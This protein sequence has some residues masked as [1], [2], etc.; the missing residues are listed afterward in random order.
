MKKNLILINLILVTFFLSCS[1]EETIENENYSDDIETSNNTESLEVSN[2]S[3][4]AYVEENS[5]EFR[6][7]FENGNLTSVNQYYYFSDSEIDLKKIEYNTNNK[8]ENITEWT[9]SG[10]LS[11]S[12]DFIYDDNGKLSSIEIYDRYTFSGITDYTYNLEYSN[13]DNTINYFKPEYGS[14]REDGETNIY[15]ASKYTI[16]L[17]ENNL[18]SRFQKD[19]EDYDYDGNIENTELTFKEEFIYDENENCISASRI[20]NFLTPNLTTYNYSFDDQINPLYSFY[21][22]NYLALFIYLEENNHVYYWNTMSDNIKDFSKNN[23]N[24]STP[25]IYINPYYLHNYENNYN[26]NDITSRVVKRSSN[27]QVL[28]TFVYQY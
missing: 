22:N 5:F 1:T 17:N 16:E 8:I 27:N 20:D 7:Y 26:D 28:G 2:I 10:T 6:H 19:Y 11:K 23:F 4:Y 15:S 14:I 12:H 21:K 3:Y 9:S 25:D 18:V 24:S 13:N